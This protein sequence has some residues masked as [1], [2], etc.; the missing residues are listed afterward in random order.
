MRACVDEKQT[1]YELELN[2]AAQ[3][4]AVTT[5][6]DWRAPEPMEDFFIEHY[7]GYNRQAEGGTME[8]EVKHPKWRTRPAELARFDFDVGKIYGPEW[9]K[10]LRAAPDAVVLADGSGVQV[11]SGDLI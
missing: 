4:M 6:G 11:F 5:N 10:V 9:A 1:A 7:W 2:G 8:Y 3:Q